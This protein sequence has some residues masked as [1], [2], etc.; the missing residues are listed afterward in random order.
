MF[1]DDFYARFTSSRDRSH[2]FE[3][4]RRLSRLDGRM[5]MADDPARGWPEWPPCIPTCPGLEKA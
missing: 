4:L 2:L 1:I 3:A 5:F